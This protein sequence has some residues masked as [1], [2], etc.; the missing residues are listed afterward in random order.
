MDAA[1]TAASDNLAEWGNK[2]SA[3]YQ[4]P[5]SANSVVIS[6]AAAASIRTHPT[7]GTPLAICSLKQR[8]GGEEKER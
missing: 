6:S 2:T 7:D 8:E 3:V 4:S 1:D 5:A